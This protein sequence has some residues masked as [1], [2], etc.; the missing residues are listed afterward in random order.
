MP[1]MG[2][3]SIDHSDQAWRDLCAVRDARPLVHNITNYVAM[4]I[5]ANVLLAVGAS[6]AMIHA[7]E[8]AAEFTAISAALTVNI[9]TVSVAWADAME[10]SMARARE[11]GIPMVFDPVGAGATEYRTRVARKLLEY[12]PTVI[13]GNAS[14][15]LALAGDTGIGATTGVDSSHS[16]DETAEAASSLARHIGGVVAVTGAVDRITDGDS[17]YLV[18]N[19]HP[20]M[21]RVTALGCALSALV[22]AFLAV[23]RPLLAATHG[24]ALYGLAGQL[25][26]DASAGPGSLRWRIVDALHSLDAGQIQRGLCIS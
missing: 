14:E 5:S 11:L 24:L 8:E 21:S 1:D 10:A 9:G 12:G 22:G 18:R 25:A 6:P 26:A 17:T 19:G 2:R 3:D 16:T 20:L 13:R 23:Q 15:I 7:V 4:D